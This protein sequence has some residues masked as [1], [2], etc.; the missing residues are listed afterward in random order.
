MKGD[1]MRLLFERGF[2]PTHAFSA[3]YRY[4]REDFGA[5]V[6]LHFGMHGALE[7]MPGKQVGLSA[8]CWPDRLIGSTP[9]IYLYA[10]NNPS[11]GALAKR[12]S[13]AT[14]VSYLTPS[15]AH[16]GLYRGLADLKASIERY[17]GCGAEADSERNR[18][19]E[20]IQ[21]QAAA[22]D[23]AEHGSAWG[24]RA[25]DE[26]GK[27]GLAILELEYT[28]IPHGLHIVGE[29]PAPGERVETL[30][31]IA[32]SAF[33]LHNADTAVRALVASNSIAA[34]A[35]AHEGLQARETRDAFEELARLNRLLAE[36]HEIPALMRVLDG[37]FVEPVVGGDL[38]RT[39]TILPTGR[40]L[41]GFD[42]YRIPSA[43]AIT[44]GARQAE[45]VLARHASDGHPFP[46]S[47][48]IVLWG[49]DNLKSEGGA[50]RPGARAHRRS[51]AFRRIWAPV[52]CNACRSRRTRPTSYRRDDDRVWNLP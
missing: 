23:L 33:G 45:C 42:P 27:L 17:R 24:P 34:A 49:T 50:D 26:I 30:S 8:S 51:A 14:L 31:V 32:E 29:P 7:F 22:V 16:A 1:P 25:P 52:R 28:L 35:E 38:I 11:E 3:F 41:H 47:V 5:D 36:D 6:V 12:R 20:L 2:A 4:L 15:L 48:A 19:A 44:D 39:P 43:F 10:A 13:A 46:E 37:R 40:N 9:N 21:S 18:L